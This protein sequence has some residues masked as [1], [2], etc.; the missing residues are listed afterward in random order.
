MNTY[1]DI[2]E[3]GLLKSFE[4]DMWEAGPKILS[5]FIEK[6]IGGRVTERRK[7]FSGNEV[8]LKFIYNESEYVV[9]EPFG[10]NN[11]Y[12]ICPADNSNSNPDVISEIQN[13][14]IKFKPGL[15]GLITG[16]LQL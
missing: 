11:R 14:F 15:K 8:H 5:E 9:W 6:E 3:N 7:W 1:P 2:D 4:I 10:D 12:T 16:F 13:E